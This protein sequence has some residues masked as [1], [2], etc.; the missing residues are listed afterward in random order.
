MKTGAGPGRRGGAHHS[1]ERGGPG[2]GGPRPIRAASGQVPG[3]AGRGGAGGG[4]W[5]NSPH[6]SVFIS[7]PFPS[8]RGPDPSRYPGRIR[9]SRRSLPSKAE[10]C[11]LCEMNSSLVAYSTFE[12]R[13]L[14]AMRDEFVSRALRHCRE[15]N[16]SHPRPSFPGILP[17]PEALPARRPSPPT[18]LPSP[19][20][21][22]SII[23]PWHTAL[24][25]PA[26]GSPRAVFSHSR[27]PFRRSK[28]WR[29]RARLLCIP[30]TGA[31]PPLNT[32]EGPPGVFPEGLRFGLGDLDGA[33]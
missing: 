25:S 16:P 23:P 17:P 21:P 18:P 24:D 3:R 33:V 10:S 4:R 31:G 28:G 32:R 6:R 5:M 19:P 29:A 20:P 9:S 22:L 12:G 14:L 15:A 1:P 11:S 7:R 30:L 2:E 13:I 27:T 8:R 26:S